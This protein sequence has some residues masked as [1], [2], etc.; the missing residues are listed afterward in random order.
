LINYF[1]EKGRGY[2]NYADF[3]KK[4]DDT[5]A[6]TDL[7]FD[8]EPLSKLKSH[9]DW[10]STKRNHIKSN[11]TYSKYPFIKFGTLLPNTPHGLKD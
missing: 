2:I 4:F 9:S 6:Q 11:N 3:A 10:L 5:A 1:D 8:R 7:N